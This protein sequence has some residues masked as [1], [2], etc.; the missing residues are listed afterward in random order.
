MPE[1]RKCKERREE[2]KKGEDWA[3]KCQKCLREKI[4][5]M[6]SIPPRKTKPEADEPPDSES[7]PGTE[8]GKRLSRFFPR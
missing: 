1:G 2:E 8:G 5:S 7:L 4:K 6:K 3:W